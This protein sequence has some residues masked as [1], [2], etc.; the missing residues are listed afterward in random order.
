[1]ATIDLSKLP[2]PAVVET[3]DYETVL[4]AMLAD[5]QAR[6][7]AFTGLVESDPAYKILE[8]CAFREV[9]IRQ[10]VN[11][12]AKACMLA[13]A[14]GT[15]LENLAG[16][17]GVTRLVIDPGNPSAVPPIAPTYET[18][19]RLRQ[20]TLLA[21][22]GVSTAG[23]VSSY[24]Y[25]A[26]SS[27]GEVRDVGITSLNPGYVNVAILATSDDGV[28]DNPLLTTV[29]AALSAETVRPLCDTVVVQAAQIVPYT[30]E[31][32]LKVY[33]GVDGQAALVAA[34]AALEAF[35]AEH[36]ALGH[37]IVESGIM[38]AL[39]QP[40]IQR[41][42]LPDWTDLSCDWSQ[43]ARCTGITLTLTGIAL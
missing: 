13:Y 9:L 22:D 30:V 29:E 33:P 26:L 4:A 7:P 17:Y 19:D 40:G 8:V 35:A 38:A 27:S 12:G 5:L 23:S 6:D 18:D 37:D 41:V 20:R 34:R 31:A 16:L 3:L 25:L 36:F 42:Q 14:V 11:D 24:R 39:H 10:R 1:M 21:L 15:D 28:P 32:E 2:A 43:A